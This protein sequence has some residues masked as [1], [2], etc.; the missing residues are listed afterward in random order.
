[1]QI[2]EH[3]SAIYEYCDSLRSRGKKIGFVPTMGA[4]HEGHF[5][6]IRK[7][8]LENEIV[9][10]S[11]F[12]NPLQFNNQADLDKYPRPLT[13]DLDALEHEEVDVVYKPSPESMYPTGNEVKIS[14]GRMAEVME[15][16][17]RPGHFDG[18]GV[19]V[20]KLFNHVIP[21][22]A[23]FGLKDLQQFLLIQRMVADLSIPV[24]VFGL[25]TVREKSGL[26]MSSRNQR[27]SDIG[28]STAAS[29]YKGLLKGK[30]RWDSGSN[31]E[32][33]KNEIEQFY[34]DTP[35]LEVEYVNIVNPHDLTEVKSNHQQSIAICVA[36]YVE[37]IRLIDNLYLRQD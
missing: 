10:V 26:A 6:L 17:F 11:I 25:P 22:Q 18:V 21:H 12:V 30:S 7:A 4:L 14:F 29:I 13:Q 24:A 32:E 9:V 28:R 37:G 5:S 19:V 36:A 20:T 16:K 33:T 8:K 35:G 31:P 15:G 1:M 34:L 27:L 2:I 23:Y 3:P